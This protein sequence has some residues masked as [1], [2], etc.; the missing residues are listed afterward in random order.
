[1]NVDIDRHSICSVEVAKI[2]E[3]KKVLP[4]KDL[5]KDKN[6]SEPLDYVENDQQKQSHIVLFCVVW[7]SVRKRKVGTD[8]QSFSS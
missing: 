2:V 4:Q 8:I 6:D 5:Y 3:R 1:M 7:I